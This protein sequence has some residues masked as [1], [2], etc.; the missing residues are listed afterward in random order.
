M[1]SSSKGITVD[2]KQ[3]KAQKL[4]QQ[5]A[6][7]WERGNYKQ[8]LRDLEK[9]QKLAP[10]NLAVLNNLAAANY[11]IGKPRAALQ[12]FRRCLALN[13]G[14]V[15]ALRGAATAAAAMGH[16]DEAAGF[17][18]RLAALD[19][20]TLSDCIEA[21]VLL[22]RA[23][24]VGPAFDLIDSTLDRIGNAAALLAHYLALGQS[25]GDPH[26]AEQKVRQALERDPGNVELLEVLARH[27]EAA[28][29][30]SEALPILGELVARQPNAA[31]ELRLA[32]AALMSTDT[33]LAEKGYRRVLELDTGNASAMNNLGLIHAMRGE[34]DMSEA[35][36]RKALVADPQMGDAWRNLS[37]LKKFSDP[38][39]ADIQAMYAAR[40]ASGEGSVHAVYLDFALGKALE[41]CGDYTRAFKHYQLANA[42]VLK[43]R[44]FDA[45]ALAAHCARIRSVFSAERL[46]Q[47]LLVANTTR[48][49]V[50]IV[51]L[52]RT[53]T[54]L[55]EQI[56]SVHPEF[57]GAGELLVMNHLVQQ[58]ENTGAR[59]PYPECITEVGQDQ[60][61]VLSASFLEEL[62]KAD[63]T[64][65]AERISDKMPYNFFHIGLFKML[66]PGGYVIECR[67]DL[68]DSCLSA[69][70]NFFPPG[71]DYTSSFEHL[72]AMCR[73]YDDMM[74]HWRAA[75]VAFHRVDYESLVAEPE[76]VLSEVC[77][78]LDI[79]YTRDLQRFHESRRPVRTISA[80]Q[81]RQPLN[82]GS[83]RRHQ[84]FEGHLGPLREALE[85]QGLEPASWLD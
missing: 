63:D 55:L 14:S 74:R 10:D 41:D 53:G 32:N 51:G 12:L 71:L 64:G 38:Q 85:R 17:L 68:L 16:P 62:R 52:P 59:T 61:M 69:W 1:K 35:C 3:K 76:R 47:H 13:A 46:A 37:A 81:V 58:L 66:F 24:Q 28:N 75:G 8:A 36:Y 4:L 70:F 57:C 31:T 67:R 5:S 49:P 72:A 27:L 20:V 29:R 77:T 73:I 33:A 7:A 39:D 82:R 19:A 56:L 2:A 48:L 18:E 22:A 9:L 42:G 25:V 78:F 34:R 21:S 6:A 26:R 23:E 50:Q 43:A 84:R 30:V 54:S 45:D 65:R 60:L 15:E 44:P 11:K 80:W 40:R 83:V 79:E